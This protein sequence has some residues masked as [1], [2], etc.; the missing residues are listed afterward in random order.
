MLTMSYALFDIG[1]S[2][3][4][5]SDVIQGRLNSKFSCQTSEF[6]KHLPELSLHTYDK[7]IVSSVVPSMDSLFSDFP[8]TIFLNHA[9]VRGLS[10]N[11]KNPEQVGADRLANA[12]G[13][14]VSH[15]LPAIMVDSG[16]AIT[17]CVVDEHKTYQGGIIFPGMGIASKALNDYTAKVPLIHVTEQSLH[18]GKNTKEAVEV[19]LYHGYIAL[20]NGYIELLKQDYQTAT[21][22]GT[23][24]GLEI[25]KDHLK[26]D[27]FDLEL[28]MVGLWAMAEQ[29]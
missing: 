4:R 7:I 20:I 9:T 28:T 21:V 11:V 18:L 15:P 14:A 1:N 12:L 13:A 8:N 5:F 26:I 22:I 24:N 23:G 27:V 2:T 6:A 19:G 10:L 29:V 3:A 16:T 17:C 25:L